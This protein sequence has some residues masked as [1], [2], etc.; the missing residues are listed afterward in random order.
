ML[1]QHYQRYPGDTGSVEVMVVL[2]TERI[3]TLEFHL[4]QHKKDKHVL[5]PYHKLCAR[6]QKFLHYLRKHRFRTYQV[7]VRDL[8]IHEGAMELFGRTY[9]VPPY[10]PAHLQPILKTAKD[11]LR[12]QYFL[13]K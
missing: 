4:A 10:I 11:V 8:G 7:L 1:L 5:R 12:T 13:M 2:L 3:N 6:R 9:D